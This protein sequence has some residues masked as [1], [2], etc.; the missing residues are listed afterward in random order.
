[1]I[2][3]KAFSLLSFDKIKIDTE[4]FLQGYEEEMYD[5][6]KAM[7]SIEDH[8]LKEQA[9]NM[10]ETPESGLIVE[11]I[12][13]FTK[14]GE[15]NVSLRIKAKKEDSLEGMIIDG[16][17]K[18]EEKTPDSLKSGIRKEIAELFNAKEENIQIIIG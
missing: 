8:Y 2:S 9:R 12:D 15:K 11:D 18:Y 3:T 1:M 7:N 10:I 6:G 16:V 4:E 13:V 17:R 5:S 14:D